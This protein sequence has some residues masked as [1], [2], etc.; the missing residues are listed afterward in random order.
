MG[1]TR[2]NRSL[3]ALSARPSSVIPRIRIK[4]VQLDHRP[5]AFAGHKRVFKQI[6]FGLISASTFCVDRH[7][8]DILR[9]AGAPVGG[10]TR[11]LRILTVAVI[12]YLSCS[13]RLRLG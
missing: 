8:M 9:N 11:A 10:I 12:S 6:S 13:L 4:F 7:P 3:P 5:P 2:R 1:E